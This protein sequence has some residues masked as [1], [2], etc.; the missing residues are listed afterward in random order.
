LPAALDCAAALHKRARIL[1]RQKRPKQNGTIENSEP[2]ADRNVPS[3]NL[4]DFRSSIGIVFYS[5]LQFGDDAGILDKP[6]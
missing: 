6:A 1:D 4:A 2:R 3:G 5:L